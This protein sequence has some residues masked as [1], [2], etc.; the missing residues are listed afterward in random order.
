MK[1]LVPR[2]AHGVPRY[3]LGDDNTW[4][5]VTS[6]DAALLERIVTAAVLWQ[7]LD[8]TDAQLCDV[9]DAALAE[10]EKVKP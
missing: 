3:E 2:H 4:A 5:C 8:Y 7:N 9:I 6:A 1:P 10:I